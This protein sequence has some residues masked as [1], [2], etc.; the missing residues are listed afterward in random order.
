M[1]VPKRVFIVPYRDRANQKAEFIKRMS[2]LLEDDAQ[3]NPYEIYF[4]HQCDKRHFNRGA[5]KNIGFIAIKNK[6]PNDYKNITFIF[7][8]VDTWPS[9]KGL[10]YY[11]TTHGIVKHFYG[12][13]HA[14]GGMFAI[15]GADFEKSQG[16]PNFWGWGLEDNIINDRCLKV[17]LKIDRSTF[18]DI[19]DKKIVRAFDGFNRIL[20]KRD[21]SVYKYE[22]PDNLNSIKNIKYTFN[23]EFINITDFTCEM[24]EKEQDYFTYDTRRGNKV[25]VPKGYFRRSWSMKTM[26]R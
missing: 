7:H 23:N 10:I 14:L 13:K 2:I 11:D 3:S 17:G 8:D 26:L 6:Y 18:Y 9:E 4:A 21:S 20:S 24:D 16:F 1:S 19:R 22:T 25:I 15:K 5:M 12:Y